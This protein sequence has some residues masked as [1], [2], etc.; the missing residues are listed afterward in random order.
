MTEKDRHGGA[1]RKSALFGLLITL[2]S[3]SVHQDRRG[4]ENASYYEQLEPYYTNDLALQP[5]THLRAVSEFVGVPI[6]LE[7]GSEGHAHVLRSHIE[8]FFARPVDEAA[9]RM[10]LARKAISVTCPKTDQTNLTE[11]LAFASSEYMVFQGVQCSG[12]VGEETQ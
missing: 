1:V 4:F 5:R 6:V 12:Y 11:K 3:C 2:A 9:A 8:L 7:D 10:D